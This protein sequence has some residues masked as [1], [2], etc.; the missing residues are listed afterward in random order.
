MDLLTKLKTKPLPK[1][2]QPV[3]ISFVS[4]KGAEIVEEIDP[5]LD[6]QAFQ[7]LLGK[8]THSKTPLVVDVKP[9]VPVKPKKKPGVKKI[10][11]KIKII[12]E[13]PKLDERLVMAMEILGKNIKDRLPEK[14][15]QTNIIETS[16]FR[17]NRQ[18]FINF[19]NSIFQPYLEK[20]KAQATDTCESVI[21]EDFSIMTH[22]EIVRDYI[23]I[24]T[25]YSGLLLYHGL[26]SGK[27]CS[28][29]AIAEG[30]KSHN[31]PNHKIIVM[32][33]ASLEK[34]YIEELKYCG[35]FMYKKTQ[36]WEFVP[37]KKNSQQANSLAMSLNLPIEYVNK[38]KGRK[39]IGVWIMDKDKPTNYNDLSEE[40]QQLLDTQI[41]EMI[42][43]KYLFIHYNG[44]TRR[45]ITAYKK[46]RDCN[47][48]FDNSV[49]IIDEA[50]NFVSR[51]VNK[52]GRNDTLTIELYEMLLDAINCRKVFLSG[53]PIINY[54]NE[55]AVMFNI[56]RGYI[57]TY[58]FNITVRSSKK[59][60]NEAMKTILLPIKQ[61]D[62]VEYI[63]SKNIIKITKN[64]F[65]FESLF[66]G[67]K[68]TGVTTGGTY[69]NPKELEKLVKEALKPHNVRV[70]KM[71]IEKELVLPD[72]LDEFKNRFIEME[73][74]EIKNEELFKKRIIGLTSYLKD[75]GELMPRYNEATDLH[76]THIPMSDY[77]FSVYEIARSDERKLERL[78]SKRKKVP[79]RDGVFA[80]SVSTYRIFSR[81]FCNFVF[82]EDMERPMPNKDDSKDKSKVLDKL[83][84]D[85][86]DNVSLEDRIQNIDGQFTEDDDKQFKKIDEIVSQDYSLRIKKALSN[87]Q[88]RGDELLTPTALE[89]YS[90]K[91][92]MI[93]ETI[94]N[95]AN[96]GKHLIYSQFRTLE[97]I[98][99]FRLVLLA[100]GF[101][102]F[103]LKN[104]GGNWG[105]DIS[106]EDMTKPKFVLYTG[107]ETAEY[108]E[109]ARNIYN[110]NWKFVPD[111]IKVQLGDPATLDNRYGEIIKVIMITASGA[112]GISL[113]STRY[114]HIVEPYWHP[115][116]MHQVI[117]R[118]QRIC[119]HQELP[120][121][122]RTVDVF[123]YLMTFT[124]AQLDS[125]ASVDLKHN[126]TSKLNPTVY[127]TSDEALFE[128][129]NIK[130][131]INKR[132]LKS[133]QETA[134]DC[135][136]Y[137]YDDLTCFSFSTTDPNKIA[138]NGPISSEQS[139]KVAIINKRKVKLEAQ[140]IS[141]DGADY[142]YVKSTRILKKY[143]DRGV[144]DMGD[145]YDFDSYVRSQKGLGN[146]IVIGK[147]LIMKDGSYKI[148]KL[149]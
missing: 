1:K 125:D 82:P 68:Y 95:P 108:K 69:I 120:E 122:D 117:G 106:E 102:E 12:Q 126:D 76:V 32:T 25:P 98:G 19:I 130:N 118:A 4:V 149:R 46:M 41:N 9:V 44:V 90:P 56:L 111:T 88:A 99:I 134:I 91:F 72:N 10:K 6:I 114:V 17:E 29:I 7:Q 63:V 81:A 39:G 57:K 8:V 146:A 11:R 128:I 3:K 103:K 141:L 143:K 121:E 115:V 13:V 71:T 14:P 28:S 140:K 45:K 84:E 30:I 80:D 133:V 62:T 36:Y 109:L 83:D 129:S 31:L 96:R 66:K 51:I 86:L 92:K 21:T 23:N 124:K 100:N 5:S 74:S 73:T 49:V 101:A 35:D 52:L 132:I 123:V 22:Q 54:P 139:D 2:R 145:L 24:Y 15:P 47:N 137:K 97:G 60:N 93:L 53:T 59:L 33:P 26:G 85:A 136:L 75:K 105:L 65:D 94:N 107:T 27:T 142:G 144:I 87:L 131:E 147:L 148:E 58:S 77:Q 37:V 110:G 138:Y 79:G 50:H 78:R 16:Y 89:N 34:N 119:S 70:D 116:R 113:K 42:Q 64:P 135:N 48:I 104:T 55:I 40:D 67:T 112:E 61:I 18:I 20:I 127:L 43:N 38:K